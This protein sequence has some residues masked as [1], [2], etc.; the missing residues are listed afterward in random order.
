MN[1]SGCNL[2]IFFPKSGCN[3][4]ILPLQTYSK[5]MECQ[6]APRVTPMSLHQT[7][8]PLFK[9]SILFE[10]LRLLVG[11]YFVWLQLRIICFHKAT[12]LS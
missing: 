9:C 3:L 4:K 2:K 7:A 12:T 11:A 1:K 5:R 8:S 10:C 6:I